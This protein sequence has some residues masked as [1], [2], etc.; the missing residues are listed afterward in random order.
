LLRLDLQLLPLVE[1][2]HEEVAVHIYWS[3]W[4][5]LHL[6][7]GLRYVAEGRFSRGFVLGGQVAVAKGKLTLEKALPLWLPG[8][9]VF[10]RERQ[11][12]IFELV[13]ARCGF[14][15]F[16]NFVFLNLGV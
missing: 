11:F 14:F 1:I 9:C 5:G 16:P 15:R 7:L 2:R 12:L 13:L 10:L 6:E 3:R 4:V 8:R